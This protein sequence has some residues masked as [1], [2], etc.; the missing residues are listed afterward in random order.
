[1][2]KILLAALS[3]PLTALAAGCVQ[4]STAPAEVRTTYLVCDKT[5]PVD[6]SHDGRMAVA[7][8]YQGKEVVM[9]RDR[10]SPGVRY[11]GSGVSVMRQDDIYILVGSDGLP[12]G[13]DLLQR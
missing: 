8:N 1:M 5:V 10:S 9:T 2:N 12:R 11:V 6:I 7:R 13:C 4:L 3:V